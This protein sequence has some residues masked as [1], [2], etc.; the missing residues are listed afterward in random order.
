MANGSC[1]TCVITAGP[2]GNLSHVSQS[3]SVKPPCV[4]KVAQWFT[5]KE[6]SG[7]IRFVGIKV[8]CFFL[9]N[10]YHEFQVSVYEFDCVPGYFRS[11]GRGIKK[12]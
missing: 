9:F 11:K 10:T 1:V 6:M 5:E 2:R 4:I 3:A 7:K 8:S 12:R